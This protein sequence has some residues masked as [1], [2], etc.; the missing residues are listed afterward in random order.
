M[1]RVAILGIMFLQYEYKTPLIASTK[2]HLLSKNFLLLSL[3]L[4][5]QKVQLEMIIIIIR[6]LLYKTKLMNLFK[7][8]FFRVDVP[9]RR[10]AVMSS[11]VHVSESVMSEIFHCEI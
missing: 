11:Y 5:A 3:S 1:H 6:G 7:H 2:S 4:R 9:L 8:L 10:N